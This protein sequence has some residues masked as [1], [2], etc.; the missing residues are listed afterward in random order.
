MNINKKFSLQ[1]TEANCLLIVIND[2]RRD[3][4]FL[5]EIDFEF[6]TTYI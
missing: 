3:K 6:V 2:G 1:K 4:N 5:K